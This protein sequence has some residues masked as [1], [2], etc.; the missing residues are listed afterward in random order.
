MRIFFILAFLTTCL[1]MLYACAPASADAIQIEDA[2]IR[3]APPGA[4]AMVGYM[5]IRNHSAKN[6]IL[7]QATSASFKAI[8][9]HRS[10]EENG[11]YKMVPHLHLH[12]ASGNKIELKPGDYHLM[13]FNPERPL[14]AGDTVEVE[15]HFSNDIIHKATV[16]VKKAE[17]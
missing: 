1:S 14:K 11:M 9:F 13:M 7:H 5:T 16:A 15:L 3:E 10:V 4:S 2:W 6:I 17:Y 8:E 12:I